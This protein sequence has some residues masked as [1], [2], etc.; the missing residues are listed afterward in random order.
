MQLSNVS[1]L[2]VR[3]YSLNRRPCIQL[4]LEYFFRFNWQVLTHSVGVHKHCRF[5]FRC[6]AYFVR[7]A[8]K[9]ALAAG[10]Y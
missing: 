1:F 2:T 7:A 5:S 9:L 4:A 3:R 6:I 8:E 10:T